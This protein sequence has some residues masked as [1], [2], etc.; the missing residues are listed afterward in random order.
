MGTAKLCKFIYQEQRI[1]AMSL[2]A[3]NSLASLLKKK[4]GDINT[5]A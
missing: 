5:S 2:C 4:S 1:I 3:T